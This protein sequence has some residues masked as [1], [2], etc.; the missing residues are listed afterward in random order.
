MTL[1]ESIKN[2][3]SFCPFNKME[4]SILESVKNFIKTSFTNEAAKL[5][6]KDAYALLQVYKK[7]FE[8]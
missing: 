1:R 6:V 2:G 7:I 3:M 8:E 5:E 4:E